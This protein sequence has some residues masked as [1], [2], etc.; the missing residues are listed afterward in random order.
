MNMNQNSIIESSHVKSATRTQKAMK[1]IRK[2]WM[3]HYLGKKITIAGIVTIGTAASEVTTSVEN[4]GVT[5]LIARDF[6]VGI[7]LLA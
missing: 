5:Q 7:P 3:A 2:I 4:P 1:R 6:G